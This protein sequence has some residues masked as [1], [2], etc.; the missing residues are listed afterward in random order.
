MTR[1]V[2]ASNDSRELF[3]GKLALSFLLDCDLFSSQVDLRI[4]H[5][6]CLLSKAA[7]IASPCHY[8]SSL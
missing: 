3:V 5:L 4:D 8:S 6:L 2:D 7:F 1:R